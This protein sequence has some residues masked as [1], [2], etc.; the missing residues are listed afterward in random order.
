MFSMQ[1]VVDAQTFELQPITDTKKPWSISFNAKV[2]YSQITRDAISIQSETGEIIPITYSISDDL[3]K[4]TVKPL[5]PYIFGTTYTLK[6]DKE[7]ASANGT[8]LSKDV[9]KQFSLQGIYIADISNTTNSWVKNVKVQVTSKVSKVTVSFNNSPEVDLRQSSNLEYEG[10]F[11]GY[12]LG[13]ELTICVYNNLGNLVE[14]QLYV[15]K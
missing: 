15:L 7:V 14:T 2:D 3:T 12:A 5:N 1:P 6:I 4:I 8:K 9:T 13:D 10:G 11:Q